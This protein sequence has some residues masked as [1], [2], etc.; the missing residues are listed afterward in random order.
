MFPR[1]FNK[2]LSYHRVTARCVLS[3]V[4]LPVATQQCRKYLYDES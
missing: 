4:I 1:E 2:K 3:V